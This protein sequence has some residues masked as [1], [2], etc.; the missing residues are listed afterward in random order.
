MEVRTQQMNTTKVTGPSGQRGK[1]EWRKGWGWKERMYKSL[2][3]CEHVSFPDMHIMEGTD[4]L[5]F[6]SLYNCLDQ[7]Q[8][9]VM[10]RGLRIHDL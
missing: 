7:T 1:V 2:C 4:A 10:K 3:Q 8:K 6:Q 5:P 9:Q